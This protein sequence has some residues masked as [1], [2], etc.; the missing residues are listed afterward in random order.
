M[1]L[2]NKQINQHKLFSHRIAQ[3]KY[4]NKRTF[5]NTLS[6]SHLLENTGNFD[7]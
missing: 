4:Y 6:R 2:F 5:L 3:S 7:L 1:R